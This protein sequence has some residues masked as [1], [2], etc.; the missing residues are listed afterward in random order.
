MSERCDDCQHE[1]K[2]SEVLDKAATIVENDGWYQGEYYQGA[3]Y[4][5]GEDYDVQDERARQKNP[6]CQR[7]AI[8]RAATGYAWVS[9]RERSE[10]PDGLF[11]AIKV[12]DEYMNRY[13]HETLGF[14]KEHGSAIAWND[15][16][17]RSAVEVAAALRGA[18][19][20]ARSEGK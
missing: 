16:S 18:A 14:P 9:Y 19:A 10:F 6:C 2:A 5:L 15:E 8:S 12:A 11:V 13:V 4:T 1:V 20:L 17:A 3:D 7:G